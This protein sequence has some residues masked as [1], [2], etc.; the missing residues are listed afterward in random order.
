MRPYHIL[1]MLFCLLLINT[2]FAQQVLYT[3]T[4]ANG[5]LQNPW[6]AGFSGNNMEVE[7]QSGNPSGDGWV[8]KLGNDLSGGGVGQ[9]WSGDLNWTDYYV[10]AQVFITVSAGLIMESN[11]G[12]IPSDSLQDT[13]L[14]PG[15]PPPACGSVPGLRP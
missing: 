11:S 2:P 5:A 1:I 7:F 13:S 14:S 12:W 10:E 9:S 4:F 15:I 6:Y 8:G 3:E